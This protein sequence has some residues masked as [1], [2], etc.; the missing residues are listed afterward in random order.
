[1]NIKFWSEIMQGRDHL[2]EPAAGERNNINLVEI[3]C[4]CVDWIHL[5]EDR[6]QWQDLLNMAMKLQIP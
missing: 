4:E 2:G 6:I 1:M 3:V 5:A